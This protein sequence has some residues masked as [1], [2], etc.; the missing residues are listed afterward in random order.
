MKKRLAFLILMNTAL[1]A[2]IFLVWLDEMDKL[3]LKLL[4]TW[5]ISAIGMHFNI[6]RNKI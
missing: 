2:L 4:A 1:I 5:G 3:E 6:I